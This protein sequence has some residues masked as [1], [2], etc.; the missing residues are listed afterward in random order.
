MKA[1]RHTTLEE[2]PYEDWVRVDLYRW[3]HGFFPN[4]PGHKPQTLDITAGIRAMADALERGHRTGKT[5]HM[6]DL[7]N[8]A[9]VLR[10]A[11][12]LLDKAKKVEDV[13]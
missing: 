12:G 2:D 4:Q 7:L 10:F 5:S 6:P 13:K 8:T 11:A 3:Q 9:L 1:P